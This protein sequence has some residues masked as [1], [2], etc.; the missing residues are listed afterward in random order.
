LF[1]NSASQCRKLHNIA[2]S[3]V[4]IDEAQNLPRELLLPVIEAIRELSDRYGTSIMLCTATQPAITV[5]DDFKDG[6]ENVREI[7]SDPINLAANLKRTDVMTVGEKTEE[8]VVRMV[9]KKERVLCIVNTRARA[10]DLFK[11]C[12]QGGNL[13]H[14][15]AAMCPAHRS[16]K[17]NEI[18]TLLAEKDDTPCRVISTQLVEAGVDLDFPCVLREIAGLDSIHQAAGRC[19]REGKREKGEVIVFEFPEGPPKL[20][21]QQAQITAALTRESNGNIMEIVAIRDYFKKLFW[22]QGT[23]SLDKHQIL[24]KIGEGCASANFPFKKIGEEFRLIPDKTRPVVIPHNDEARSIIGQ[25]KAGVMSKAV[26]RKAQRY[27]VSVYEKDF[28]RLADAGSIKPISETMYYLD[29][30]DLYDENLG[31]NTD[32]PFFRSSESNII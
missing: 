7:I 31:L 30:T 5:N 12:N 29:N 22:L 6:L 3:V 13:F 20:F 14:L 24:Q 28:L 2:R 23:E 19:N 1:S 17:L 15:S 9:R 8:D 27:S 16:R 10:S 18:R 26:F 25:L 4:I 11:L 21:L 32:D